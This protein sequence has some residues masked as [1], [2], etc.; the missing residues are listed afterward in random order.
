MSI[1]SQ[2][3]RIKGNIRNT[4]N[5]IKNAGINVPSNSNSDDLPAL[6]TELANRL[7]ISSIDISNNT[8]KSM[9]VDGGSLLEPTD[10]EVGGSVNV[11]G[12]IA[13]IVVTNGTSTN[14]LSIDDKI[15]QT[16]VFYNNLLTP[17]MENTILEEK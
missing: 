16:E 15:E 3:N 14:S 11:T 17:I 4:L 7:G 8:T 12:R 6:T 10:I 2:I 5:I 13:S 9:H 1:Q